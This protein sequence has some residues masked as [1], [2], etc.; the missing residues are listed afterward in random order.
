MYLTTDIHVFI[1]ILYSATTF[2]F[3]H[4]NCILHSE[5]PFDDNWGT[6]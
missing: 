5:E 2:R 6:K 1:Y 4:C 3:N